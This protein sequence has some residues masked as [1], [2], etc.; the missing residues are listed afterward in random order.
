[1]HKEVSKLTKSQE[2]FEAVISSL[3][4]ECQHQ[5][6]E[7]KELRA[8]MKDLTDACASLKSE[9]AELQEKICSVQ[10]TPTSISGASPS[11]APLFSDVVKQSVKAA[12]RDEKAK[13]DV[14]VAKVEE[15]GND[16][17][18]MSELCSK[19]N[20]ETK[21]IDVS[22]LGKKSED[23]CRPLKVS[24]GCRFEARTF[25]S[26]FNEAKSNKANKEIQNLRVHAWRGKEEHATYVK[27]RDIAFKLNEEARKAGRN[28]Y[29]SYSVRENGDM[30]KF[31]KDEHGKWNRVQD[32]EPP[33]L[34]NKQASGNEET[35]PKSQ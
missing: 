1:M 10:K 4:A 29:E 23:R 21:P 2:E 8:A 30:W 34:E 32:W 26:R 25:C 5:R 35:T 3:Q 9:N 33:A 24:F 16:L 20:F 6:E 13:S 15:K 18:V 19:I 22:R 7:S 14:V 12:M 11:K 31:T 17:Q 27:S 28:D